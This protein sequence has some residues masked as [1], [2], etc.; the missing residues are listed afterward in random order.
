MV[1]PFLQSPSGIGLPL[2]GAPP[3]QGLDALLVLGAGCVIAG[4]LLRLGRQRS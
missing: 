3:V 4:A 1:P 2:V